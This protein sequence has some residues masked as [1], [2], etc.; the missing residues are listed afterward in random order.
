MRGRREGGRTPGEDEVRES[1][2]AEDELVVVLEVQLDAAA[3]HR[4]VRE[5]LAE[6]HQRRDCRAASEL[7]KRR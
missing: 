7:Y 5:E 6:E 3:G 2:E 4:R 1:D